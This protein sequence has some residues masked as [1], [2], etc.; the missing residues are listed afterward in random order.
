MDTQTMNKA[1]VQA[2][3]DSVNHYNVANE[4]NIKQVRELDMMGLFETSWM[5]FHHPGKMYGY[6]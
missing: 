2:S 4:S 1:W 6:P 5:I 3:H